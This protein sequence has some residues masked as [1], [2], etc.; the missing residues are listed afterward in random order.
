[1]KRKKKGDR[2]KDKS[3]FS[4]N[5]SRLRAMRG[6]TQQKLSEL[7]GIAVQTISS[8]ENS[9]RKPKIQRLNKIAKAL[10]VNI[11]DIDPFYRYEHPEDH[12]A[13]KNG[14]LLQLIINE[15]STLNDEQKAE[16]LTAIYRI[17]STSAKNN[18]D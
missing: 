6:L 3:Q 16:I 8:Y 18:A 17:K 9:E 15:V 11:E 5:L 12:D 2:V 10:G 13:H 7:T 4:E 1:M 14:A